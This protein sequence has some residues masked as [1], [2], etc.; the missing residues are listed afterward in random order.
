M[1][2]QPSG[3]ETRIVGLPAQMGPRVYEKAY[4]EQALQ[5]QPPEAGLQESEKYVELAQPDDIPEDA[6]KTETGFMPA[7]YKACKRISSQCRKQKAIF[8]L[9]AVGSGKTITSLCMAFNMHPSIETTVIT[10]NGLQTAFLEEYTK[11]DSSGIYTR[12]DLDKKFSEMRCIF[13]D[14]FATQLFALSLMSEEARL[15]EIKKYFKN[16]FLILDE[17]HKLLPILAKDSTGATERMLKL[18][19]SSAAKVVLMTATPLQRDWSDFGKLMKLL[20]QINSP[21]SYGKIRVWDESTFKKTFWFPDDI[22]PSWRNVDNVYTLLFIKLVDWSDLVFNLK[23][24]LN[25]KIGTAE[26]VVKGLGKASLPSFSILN[27]GIGIALGY[28][29]GLIS[30]LVKANYLKLTQSIL[31]LPGSAL[32]YYL[33]LSPAEQTRGTLLSL[34]AVAALGGSYVL[35]IGPILTVGVPLL[36]AVGTKALLFAG[37]ALYA[38]ICLTSIKQAID[39]FSPDAEPFDIEHLCYLFNPLIS[40]NDYKAIEMTHATTVKLVIDKL[41]PKETGPYISPPLPHILISNKIRTLKDKAT[42]AEDILVAEQEPVAA[43]PPEEET[44]IEESLSALLDLQ[45]AADNTRAAAERLTLK[46]PNQVEKATSIYKIYKTRLESIEKTLSRFPVLHVTNIDV[47]MDWVQITK[48]YFNLSK[49]FAPLSS[50]LYVVGRISTDYNTDTFSYLDSSFI[51]LDN[52]QNVMSALRSIGNYSLDCREYLPVQYETWK[53]KTQTPGSAEKD[54]LFKNT[55]AALKMSPSLMSQFHG[56][57]TYEK[58]I[59]P[60]L[61][62]KNGS[63]N[64]MSELID[65]HHK[66]NT[67]ELLAELS[68]TLGPVAA[69]AVNESAQ[70]K[71]IVFSCAKFDKALEIITE[72]RKQF[73]YL[74]VVYSNFQDQGLKRFSAFLSSHNLPHYVLQASQLAENP[75]FIQDIQK[76]YLRWV[77]GPSSFHSE[78]EYLRSKPE[79][80]LLNNHAIYQ[81]PCC[82]LLDPTLQEGLSLIPNEVMICLEP[83]TGYGNQEQVYGRIVRTYSDENKLINIRNYEI[84]NGFFLKERSE[85]VATQSTVAYNGRKVADTT[86]TLKSDLKL[87]YT[88]FK[89]IE[90]QIRDQYAI[91]RDG[92]VD[93]LLT[94]GSYQSDLFKAN[95]TYIS[96]LTEP[97]DLNYRPQK[98]CFQ[99]V[100]KMYEG[101]KQDDI[102]KLDLQSAFRTYLN[103]KGLHNVPMFKSALEKL[104]KEVNT[105][106]YKINDAL[107]LVKDREPQVKHTWY[108]FA[109]TVITPHFSYAIDWN[110]FLPYSMVYSTLC[111][112]YMDIQVENPQKWSSL[113]STGVVNTGGH[114]TAD[115]YWSFK[116]YMQ[117]QEFYKLRT[118]LSK[119]EENDPRKYLTSRDIEKLGRKDHFAS[120]RYQCEDSDQFYPP[121]AHTV[122]RHCRTQ[123]RRTARS[124][125]C[126]RAGPAL[127]GGSR[128]KTYK[129]GSTQVLTKVQPPPPHLVLRLKS[130]SNSD[131]LEEFFATAY[132]GSTRCDTIC[133]VRESNN[134]YV[135]TLLTQFV[136]KD[137]EAATQLMQNLV[138]MD[139]ENNNVI[140]EDLNSK[141][142]LMGIRVITN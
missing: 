124:N 95:S 109:R 15:R 121:A 78:I 31:T 104:P 108:E 86:G 20:G 49:G 65:S 34:V 118:E 25:A 115:Q 63:R 129:G 110:K 24:G 3:Y 114:P 59:G 113:A 88:N 8:L 6:I 79:S 98:F 12:A 87:Q 42:L 44:V 19:L 13:Y 35:G 116:N 141:T 100:S 46:S 5:D 62:A 61:E 137:D 112:V 74:P 122:G 131:K 91:E 55:Y 105:F 48:Q 117:E 107:D 119:I 94:T 135:T 70:P 89:K 21:G 64:T 81:Q 85:I 128:R 30:T 38:R 90:R 71:N 67:A 41:L 139:I 36:T 29:S 125:S 80:A 111:E 75:D 76:P 4:V 142:L 77:S 17:A 102:I 37:S 69:A 9:H 60:A 27:A 18:V 22:S 66:R 106:V 53:L 136:G 123:G 97:L 134:A 14:E 140:M 73:I 39:L 72:A 40:F 7:Q 132:S 45:I 68:K 10:I 47:K 84:Y 50:D 23:L 93:Y 16:R 57:E 1:S 52:T 54:A 127:V 99:L 101:P 92:L 32:T 11:L 33:K 58:D 2:V 83:M 138:R 82:V 130:Q 28:A 133:D 126:A 43:E 51:G 103:K 56:K 26:M 120:D 96:A